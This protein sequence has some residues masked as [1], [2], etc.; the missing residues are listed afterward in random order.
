MFDTEAAAQVA[1]DEA[2]AVLGVA[3]TLDDAL[4]RAPTAGSASLG[5]AQG[6]TL[7]RR[8]L[9]TI[10]AW[11]EGFSVRTSALYGSDRWSG[12]HR[13][14]ADAARSLVAA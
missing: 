13:T 11:P 2:G 3:I 5:W 6:W 8:T 1:L 10:G 12:V 14:I 9:I 4:S 7:D